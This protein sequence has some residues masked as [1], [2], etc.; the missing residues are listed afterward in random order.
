MVCVRTREYERRVRAEMRK[1]SMKFDTLHIKLVDE[2]VF[3][4][5]WSL[6]FSTSLSSVVIS[7][8]LQCVLHVGER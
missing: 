3:R 7:L 4:G 6:N 2:F 1:I 5:S 8:T